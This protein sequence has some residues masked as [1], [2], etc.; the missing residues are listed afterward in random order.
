MAKP[1][2][3]KESHFTWPD[4][5]VL[6]GSA[7]MLPVAIYEGNWF[8]ITLGVAFAAVIGVRVGVTL[9]L[10]RRHQTRK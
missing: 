2:K 3:S 9:W 5:V 10:V 7:L 6:A 1:S 4:G 8:F